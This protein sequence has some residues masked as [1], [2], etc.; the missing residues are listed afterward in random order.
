VTGFLSEFSDFWDFL[1]DT[2]GVFRPQNIAE[3]RIRGLESS[4]VADLGLGLSL[5][6]SYTLTD[7]RYEKFRGNEDVEDNRLDDNVKHRGSGFLT[8]R[9]EDGHAVRLGVLVSGDR[10]TDP[11]NT[12]AGHL[13]GFYVAELQAEG[14]I[15]DWAAVTLNIQNALN[16]GYR[17]RPEFREPSRAIFLGFRLTF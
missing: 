17:I 14:R 12:Q 4:L 10:Y 3:V 8:W 2:D 6:L 5:V 11:E 7:A 15:T 9:H 13:D 1:P 16:H